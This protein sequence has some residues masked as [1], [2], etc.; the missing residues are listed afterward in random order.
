MYIILPEQLLLEEGTPIEQEPQHSKCSVLPVQMEHSNNSLEYQECMECL[1]LRIFS[2]ISLQWWGAFPHN[3]NSSNNNNK[4]P[5]SLVTWYP[6]CRCH[7]QPWQHKCRIWGDQ[8]QPQVRLN[9]SLRT[10]PSSKQ[11]SMLIFLLQDQHTINSNITLMMTTEK[12]KETKNMKKKMKIQK[13]EWLRL[14][15]ETLLIHTQAQSMRHQL[16]RR[17][18]VDWHALCAWK[19]WKPGIE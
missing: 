2:L 3:S 6:T 14:K 10:T 19:C 4:I 1:K 9:I 11:P 17:L 13:K 18:V 7:L 5:T 16:K 12:K 8:V 15:L